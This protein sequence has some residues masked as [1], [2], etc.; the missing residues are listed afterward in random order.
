[1]ARLSRRGKR[2]PSQSES[3]NHYWISYADL[4]AS[5]LLCFIL[6]SIAFAIENKE[7]T[8]A[9]E[10]K[11]K[12]INEQIGVKKKIIQE[13]LKAFQ[14]SNLMKY[15]HI[16]QQTGAITFDG[17]VFFDTNS[18]TISPTG[19]KNLEIFIPKYVSVL[20][21]DRFRKD[22]S[23]IIIE[24]HTDT[25]GG[26]LYNLRLSQERAL[27]VVEAIFDDHFPN[28]PHKNE[29]QKVITA[30]GRSFSVPI[31][32]KDGKID[33]AKSRRVEF[34]FRLKD[35]EA[36]DQIRQLVNKNGK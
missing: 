7:A 26:Y 2:I 12:I 21:S 23:Q 32:A 3:H 31:L 17:G 14:D 13:L 35:E 15:M 5:L 9:M 10:Q 29:L 11:D 20:L 24:G 18:T 25:S 30:N 28:F 27:A 34:K 4:L 33:A 22:I 19:R 1:M 6:F 16:D 36:L 8:E